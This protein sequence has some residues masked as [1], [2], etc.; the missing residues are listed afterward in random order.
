MLWFEL[1]ALIVICAALLCVP[2]FAVLRSLGFGRLY[3]LSLAPVV[4]SFFVAVTCVLHPIV[5][6]FSSWLSV[7]A[8][9]AMLTAV[10]CV[11]IRLLKR[12]G[13]VFPGIS[14]PLSSG[15]SFSLFGW[16]E[17]CTNL[18]VWIVA[19]VV[20]I[21][22]GSF[23]F[24]AQIESPDSFFQAFDNASHMNSIAGFIEKGNWSSFASGFYPSC[25]IDL[26]SFLSSVMDV[27]VSLAENAVNFAFSFV[28]F[29]LGMALLLRVIFADRPIAVLAGAVL[30]T[31]CAGFPWKL[32]FFGPIYPNLA[33]LAAL[34]SV[35][36]LFVHF[37]GGDVSKSQ[38]IVIVLAFIAS[39]GGLFFLQPNVLFSAVVFLAPFCAVHA[40]RFAGERPFFS[41]HES[42]GRV[43]GFSLC[44]VAIL[45]IWCALYKTSFIQGLLQEPGIILFDSTADAII[46]ALSFSLTDGCPQL[47]F[48]A[49]CLAGSVYALFDRRYLW[50]VIS[51]VVSMVTFVVSATDS[52]DLI[53]NVVT[54]CWY[55]DAFRLAANTAV[56]SVPL[57]ALGVAAVIQLLQNAMG[58]LLTSSLASK[59]LTF[60]LITLFAVVNYAPVTLPG[61]RTSA[62]EW[63]EFQAGLVYSDSAE[64]NI[65]TAEEMTFAKRVKEIVGEDALVVNVPDDGSVFL[66]AEEG[67]NTFY[68]NTRIWNPSAESEDSKLFRES[69]CDLTT[70]D[71][72]AEAVEDA[73]AEYVLLLDQGATIDDTERVWLFTWRWWADWW[74]GLMSISDETPGFEVALAEGDMRL[75]AIVRDKGSSMV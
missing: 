45:F 73:G 47:V 5:G 42:V 16:S 39:C 22:L 67:I 9:V 41:G 69:M 43:I 65:L 63:V 60:G 28:V 12:G 24:L 11:I 54:G 4:S 32:L 46:A 50:I 55:H 64:V 3:A 70:N 25:W 49:L 71:R 58:H 59:A 74:D 36:A 48:A 10:F 61:G 2:G 21:L 57:A 30:A 33:A 72:V 31:A 7:L 18:F 23:F 14:L 53:R 66:Y 35:M 6:V 62:F 52:P 26:A 17:R 44:S 68:R 40:A 8:T 20:G 13:V 37:F 29:P 56:F 15:T 27:P 1:I 51:V 75:Y 34:P 19:L 38:R